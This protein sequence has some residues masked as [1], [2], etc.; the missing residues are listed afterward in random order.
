MMALG[1]R[2]YKL[3]KLIMSKRKQNDFSASLVKIWKC[4]DCLLPLQ[5]INKVWVKIIF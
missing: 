2:V 5:K 4:E 1:R 3:V